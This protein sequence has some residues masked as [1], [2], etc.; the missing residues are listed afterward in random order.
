MPYTSYEVDR[1]LKKRFQ[2]RRLT[3]KDAAFDMNFIDRLC[4]T[5]TTGGQYT[6]DA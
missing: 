3:L 2:R 5:I 4:E 6:V 1:L